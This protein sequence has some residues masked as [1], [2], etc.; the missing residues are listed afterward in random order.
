MRG[1]RGAAARPVPPYPARRSAASGALRVRGTSPGHRHSTHRPWPACPRSQRWWLPQA[2]GCGGPSVPFIPVPW[3]ARDTSDARAWR[4]A[5]ELAEP[6]Q[7]HTA[8]VAVRSQR[9]IA[10]PE[11]EVTHKDHRVQ[12]WSRWQSQCRDGSTA[13]EDGVA[14]GGG[15]V[16]FH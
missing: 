9:V 3:P 15:E 16:M 10:S 6:P 8:P 11:L 13:M 12:R 7:G 1:G 4:V 14:G 5:G 2:S